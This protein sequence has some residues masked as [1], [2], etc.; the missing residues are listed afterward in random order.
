VVKNLKKILCKAIEEMKLQVG[1]Q[2]TFNT[3]NL[4]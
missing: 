4:K 1:V 3:R 2:H